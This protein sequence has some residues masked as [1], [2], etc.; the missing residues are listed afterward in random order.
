MQEKGGTRGG[1]SDF[2]WGNQGEFGRGA[3]SNPAV[4][5]WPSSGGG[6]GYFGGG[7]GGVSTNCLGTGAGGSSFVSGCK[8]C[9]AITED[10]SSTNQK[11]SGN[12]HYSGYVFSSITM[13]GGDTVNRYSKDGQIKISL[14]LSNFC[15]SLHSHNKS[16]LFAFI[17]VLSNKITDKKINHKD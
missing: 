1:G 5:N 12:V 13:K 3:D 11:F 15:T 6:S 9:S 4:S 7:S 17:I 14:L 8:G 16:M 2:A 10:Y